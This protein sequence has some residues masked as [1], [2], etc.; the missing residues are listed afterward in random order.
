VDLREKD[1]RWQR[2]P[3]NGVVI[4]EVSPAMSTRA[5]GCVLRSEMG[6]RLRPGT[7]GIRDE[8]TRRHAAQ[9]QPC[10]LSARLNKSRHRP[11][12]VLGVRAQPR[13]RWRSGQYSQ[14][15]G[16]AL[17]RGST[18]FC[19]RRVHRT[20]AKMALAPVWAFPPSMHAG[21]TQRWLME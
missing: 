4:V 1:L 7:F 6:T 11:R 21:R 17:L 20:A 3:A 18:R 8:S 5:F 12:S 10:Q 15:V 2:D 16:K 19:P 14:Q 9:V 13:Q